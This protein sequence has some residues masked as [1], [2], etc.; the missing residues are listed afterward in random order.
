[1]GKYFL[2]SRKLLFLLNQPK[3]K[4]TTIHYIVTTVKTYFGM[5][6]N[7]DALRKIRIKAGFSQETMAD[8]MN[9]RQSTYNRLENGKTKL[10][11]EHIPKIASAVEKTQEEV[12]SQLSGCAISTTNN[13]NA[14]YNQNLVVNISDE[15]NL[16]KFLAEKDR[17]IIS[18]AEQLKAKDE[19]I[20]TQASIIVLLQTELD[21]LKVCDIF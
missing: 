8:L 7:N 9:V 15:K 19:T 21:K 17:Y 4:L 5:T 10:K 13:D 3:I 20:K 6:L 12:L 2:F 1:M 16:Q 14:Q 18:Q 11:M